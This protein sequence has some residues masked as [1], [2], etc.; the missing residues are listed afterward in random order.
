MLATFLQFGVAIF[1]WKE[2]KIKLV[3]IESVENRFLRERDFK[4]LFC[5]EIPALH[6]SVFGVLGELFVNIPP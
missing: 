3:F 6:K 1:V 5:I 4:S 2:K